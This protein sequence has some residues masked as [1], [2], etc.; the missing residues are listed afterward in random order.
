MCLFVLLKCCQLNLAT[1]LIHDLRQ[2]KKHINIHDT[3]KHFTFV[4]YY[5][6]EQAEPFTDLEFIYITC[7]HRIVIICARVRL[8]I[9]FI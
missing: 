3:I 5:T 2:K 7:A 6:I 8:S 1:Y 4:L 9:Y